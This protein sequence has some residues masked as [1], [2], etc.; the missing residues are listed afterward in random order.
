VIKVNRPTLALFEAASLGE[1]TG[2]L[3]SVFRV[4]MLKSHIEELCQLWDG[5]TQFVSK[6]V[7]YTLGGRRRGNDRHDPPARRSEQ[8]VLSGLDAQLL[9]GCGDVPAWRTS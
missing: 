9:D 8:P 2:N 4:D 6:T 3:G 1:L 5:Q 7:N